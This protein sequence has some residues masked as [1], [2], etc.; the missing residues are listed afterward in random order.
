MH[1]KD[2]TAAPVGA[3]SKPSHF[4]SFS[5]SRWWAVLAMLLSVVGI[6]AVMLMVFR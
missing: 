2:K 3:S 6:V 4:A 1:T 5:N